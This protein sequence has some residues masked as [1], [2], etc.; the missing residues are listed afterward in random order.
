MS[1]HRK[2]GSCSPLV[3]RIHDLHRHAPLSCLLPADHQ[4]IVLIPQLVHHTTTAISTSWPYLGG[5][6]HS[7][8]VLWTLGR[9]CEYPLWHNLLDQRSPIVP[10]PNHTTSIDTDAPAAEVGIHRPVAHASEQSRKIGS[11]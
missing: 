1:S 7:R 10:I 5:G 9:L 2:R 4:R 11:S 8:L 6:E 3:L